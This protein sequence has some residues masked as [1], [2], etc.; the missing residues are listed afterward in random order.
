MA[1]AAAVAC[2]MIVATLPSDY[3]DTR[4][5]ARESIRK[6]FLSV[7]RE[8]Y[9][10]ISASRI[11]RW[12]LLG[13]FLVWFAFFSLYTS[14]EALL[15]QQ[16]RLS[17]AGV[18]F[19]ALTTGIGYILGGQLEGRLSDRVAR[20]TV[21]LAGL[22]LSAVASVMLAD[23]SELRFAVLGVLAVGFWLFL[24]AFG[25]C[26]LDD[27]PDP[28]GANR[29]HVGQLLLELYG[30]DGGFSYRGSDVGLGRVPICGLDVGRFVCVGGCSSTAA[31]I[32]ESLWHRNCCEWL[33]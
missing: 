16:F 12:A 20:R 32:R 33:R 31:F 18:G 27:G 22:G 1:T 19:V 17:N 26:Y 2:L 9:G 30:Y 28:P 23:V 5:G 7:M 29:S 24:D 25:S 8:T 14:L 13:S 3:T 21:M 4:A 15:K 6:G 11:T 10:L